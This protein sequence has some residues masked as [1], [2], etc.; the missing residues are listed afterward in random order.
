MVSPINTGPAALP[1][2]LVNV[3]LSNNIAQQST[4][5]APSGRASDTGTAT[6]GHQPDS[7]LA[8][9]SDPLERTIEQINDSMKAWSTGMRFEIDEDAQRVVVSIVDSE[10]GE[11]LRTVPSDAV[12]R[13]AKMIVQLQGGTINVRA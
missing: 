5:I 9:D 4:T 8:H 12:L 7:N 11:V 6:T 3:E 10:S 1:V 2:D 13:V